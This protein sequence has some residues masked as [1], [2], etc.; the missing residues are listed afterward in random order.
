ME[1][2]KSPKDTTTVLDPVADDV[3]V[4]PLP[5]PPP[6]SPSPT[7]RPDRPNFD[8]PSLRRAEPV[9]EPEPAT[10]PAPSPPSP[11]ATDSFDDGDLNDQERDLLRQL[12]EELAKRE[13]AEAASSSKKLSWQTD[14]SGRHSDADAKWSSPSTPRI[15]NGVPPTAGGSAEPPRFPPTV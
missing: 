2:V 14:R 8:Q 11:T 6:L 12:Q 3:V 10:V 13:Q 4:D 7:P 5:P 9:D 1:P 15:I